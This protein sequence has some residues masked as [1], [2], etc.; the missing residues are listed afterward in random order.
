MIVDF[1]FIKKIKN[2][3]NEKKFII[4]KLY[5]GK[6]KEVIPPN[7]IKNIT[8]IYKLFFNLIYFRNY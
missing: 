8:S 7:K 5:G 3:D 6:L 2:K 4:K 1:F